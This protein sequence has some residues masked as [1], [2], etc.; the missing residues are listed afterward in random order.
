MTDD[1]AA[2]IAWLAKLDLPMG[3][4]IDATKNIEEEAKKIW[5]KKLKKPIW[6]EEK[7]QEIIHMKNIHEK[8]MKRLWLQKLDKLR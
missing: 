8:E 4:H 1:N 7:K 2:K 5:L 6:G 3:T